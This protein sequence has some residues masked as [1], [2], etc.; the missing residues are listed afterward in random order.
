MRK[1]WKDLIL[2]A[3]PFISYLEQS[4]YFYRKF[5]GNPSGKIILFDASVGLK[6]ATD[7]SFDIFDEWE[8]VSESVSIFPADFEW[9]SWVDHALLKNRF[10]DLESKDFH[11]ADQK[12]TTKGGACLLHELMIRDMKI[13]LNCYS[14]EYFPDIWTP[15]YCTALS[16]M[17][18]A[19]Y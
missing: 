13:I 11:G 14:N 9:S 17:E 2:S 10:F 1:H 12:W 6:Y 19:P 5:H 15:G 18:S 7:D 3:A 8:Q 4:S 16:I